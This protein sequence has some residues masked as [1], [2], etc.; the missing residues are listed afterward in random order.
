MDVAFRNPDGST[1]LV[2]LNDNAAEQSFGV[3]A[4]GRSLRYTL[5]PHA[6]ATFTW[7][8]MS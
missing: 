7:G 2:V 6:V 8:Q 3:Q 4:E 5:P 1:A